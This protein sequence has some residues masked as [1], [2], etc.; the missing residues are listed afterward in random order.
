M[1]DVAE[2]PRPLAFVLSGGA[3]LGGAQVGHLLVLRELGILPDLIVGTSVGAVNG[4]ALAVDPGNGA[5]R[6]LD[7]W[8]GL[9]RAAVFPGLSLHRLGSRERGGTGGVLSS[10]GLT[11]LIAGNLEVALLEDL[12]VPLHVIATDAVT[13]QLVD[14]THGPIIDA[15][16]ASSAI[17]GISPPRVIDGR[18]LMDGGLV[19]NV[20]VLHAFGLGART[21]IVLDATWPCQLTGPPHT[22]LESVGVALRLL[23]RN[24]A[25]AQLHAA[26]RQGLVVHL[27][28]PCTPR[29]SAFDFRGVVDVIEATAELTEEFFEERAGLPWPDVGAVG[30]PHRHPEEQVAGQAD[31]PV[32]GQPDVQADEQPEP[33]GR[34]AE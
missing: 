1:T 19:A 21:A 13:G 20:P 29:R 9:R 33:A 26:A 18:T 14:L 4:V 30:A 34:L 16:V 17:P 15:V 23:T 7:I 28:I 11:A 12:A 31:P 3:A 27:P 2:F 10:G 6:L 22:V 25:D 8:A 5:R 24:Q 32:A